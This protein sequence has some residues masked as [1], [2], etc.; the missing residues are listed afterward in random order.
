[1]SLVFAT[2]VASLGFFEWLIKFLLVGSFRPDSQVLRSSLMLVELLVAALQ[3]TPFDV[4]PALQAL[5]HACR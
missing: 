4:A 3:D 2:S 1:M 5:Y